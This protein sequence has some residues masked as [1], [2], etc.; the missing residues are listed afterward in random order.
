MLQLCPNLC[1]SM[2][3]RLLLRRRQESWSRLPCPP[4]GALPHPGIETE[5]SASP[6]L[7]ADSLPPSHQRSP[8]KVIL[9]SFSETP[10]LAHAPRWLQVK[11]WFSGPKYSPG[12]HVLASGPLRKDPACILQFASSCCSGEATETSHLW[13]LGGF[14]CG[15]L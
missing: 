15:V 2:V 1:E 14:A 9:F 7:Q 11:G 4:P 8:S 6:A 10:C 5:S 3:A 12:Q 13:C